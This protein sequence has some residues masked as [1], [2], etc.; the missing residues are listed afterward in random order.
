M[1]VISKTKWPNTK[2]EL[3]GYFGKNITSSSKINNKNQIKLIVSIQVAFETSWL[4]FHL[5]KKRGTFAKLRR[6]VKA[7]ISETGDIN[8]Q[9][10]PWNEA[11]LLWG[12]HFYFMTALKHLNFYMPEQC[13][14]AILMISFEGR[15]AAK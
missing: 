5:Q 6:T 13:S 12:L 10:P 7:A 4:K 3:L 1:I 2:L 11:N 8:Q 9:L 14:A 15:K